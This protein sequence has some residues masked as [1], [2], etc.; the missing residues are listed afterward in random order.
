M[1]I[2]S[3]LRCTYLEITATPIVAVVGAK[4]RS[5]EVLNCRMR[6]T[7]ADGKKRR[8]AADEKRRAAEGAKVDEAA[9][10]EKS[11]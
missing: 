7:G 8:E 9:A 4:L 3:S 10:V 1:S 2:P 6:L 11:N 5:G